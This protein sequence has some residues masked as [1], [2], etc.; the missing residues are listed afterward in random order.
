MNFKEDYKFW[1]ENEIK[2]LEYL[3]SRGYKIEAKEDKMSVLDFVMDKDGKNVNIEL[4]TR[5]CNRDT[6]KDTL[7]WANK[8]AEAY[9]KFYK[10]WE[11]TLFFFSY[12][13][14]LFYI[15]PFDSIPR[16]E[17]K[18]QR[19]DRWIDKPKWWLYF[20]TLNLKKIWKKQI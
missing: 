9:N 4:K 16:R 6:Y 17:F 18:L 19:W 7:I 2:I 1:T 13:D 10:N 8:L 12:K 20:N 11:E 14:W 5:R 3:K 15:N